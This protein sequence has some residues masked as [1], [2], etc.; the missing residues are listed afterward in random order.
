MMQP[1][2]LNA[3]EQPIKVQK[4]A[5]FFKT[6]IHLSQPHDQ[7]QSNTSVLVMELIK[8]VIFGTMTPETFVS[9]IEEALR[10]LRQPH[11]LPYL[12][13]TLPAL[14]QALISG[15]LVIDNLS[16][17]LPFPPQHTDTVL[18]FPNSDIL[19]L[20]SASVDA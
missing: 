9:R 16:P 15:E 18:Y 12:R 2:P 8:E 13:Q 1:S 14:R 10:S 11:L 5:R 3:A 4:C 17:P 6:L 20:I 19:D 7:I